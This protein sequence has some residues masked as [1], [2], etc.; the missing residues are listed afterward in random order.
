[1]PQG[2]NPRFQLVGAGKDYRVDAIVS[3]GE[4]RWLRRRW[5]SESASGDG[6]LPW[7]YTG[8]EA[9]RVLSELTE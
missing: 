8:T 5:V 3:I 4:K 6:L 2:I 7:R 9:A 1:M